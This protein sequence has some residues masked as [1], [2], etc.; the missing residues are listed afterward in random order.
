MYV[1]A[2][3]EQNLLHCQEFMC[4]SIRQILSTFDHDIGLQ[5]HTIVVFYTL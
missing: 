4:W 2:E 3:G 5:G 1:F